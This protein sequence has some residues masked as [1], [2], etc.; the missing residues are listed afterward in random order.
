VLTTWYDDRFAPIGDLALA[1][2]ARYCR[3][4]GY[5]LR[6]P[7]VPRADRP[8]PWH[9]IE[10]LLALLDEAPDLVLWIDADAMIVRTDRAAHAELPADRDLG[11]VKHVIDGVVTVNTGV[12]LLR[13]TDPV[14]EW[15]EV[16]WRHEQY[17]EHPWWENAAAMEVLG[18][19]QALADGRKDEPD[20][21]WERH[22]HWLGEEWNTLPGICEHD[23]PIIRHYAARSFEYRLANMR[24]DAGTPADESPAT[25]RALTWAQ[26]LRRALA[27]P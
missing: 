6:L 9:K 21:R 25:R 19:R 20:P 7:S 11:L 14:R 1:S 15:L 27:G 2:A 23:Q 22:V 5:E 8:A 26:R 16:I 12:L 18:Y 10:I 24:A 3:A 13:A 4:Q 17:L